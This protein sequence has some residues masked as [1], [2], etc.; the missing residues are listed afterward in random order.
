MGA[1][2]GSALLRRTHHACNH[3][4]HLVAERLQHV[5]LQL[6]EVE[7][8]R[9]ELALLMPQVPAGYQDPPAKKHRQDV[10]PAARNGNDMSDI[11]RA[12]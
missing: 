9:K 7:D 12:W 4:R 3:A 11:H 6:A 5:C 8:G 10:I 2:P 1:L